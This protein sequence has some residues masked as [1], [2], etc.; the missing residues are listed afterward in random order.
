MSNAAANGDWSEGTLD[1]AGIAAINTAGTTQLRVYFSLDDNDDGGNDY[2][3]FYAADN[4]SSANHPQLVVTYQEWLGE[5]DVL[6][7]RGRAYARP[8]FDDGL[9]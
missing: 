1:A 8:F 4:S 6:V 3:G 5:R 2:I 9:T 7:S